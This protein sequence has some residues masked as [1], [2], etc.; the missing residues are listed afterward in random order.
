MEVTLLSA[1]PP[2]L[3]SYPLLLAMGRHH[4]ENPKNHG[5]PWL[6]MI[7]RVAGKIFLEL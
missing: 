7:L 2:L 1:P 3:L 6:E 5:T 4:F